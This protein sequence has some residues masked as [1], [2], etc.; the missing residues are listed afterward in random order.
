[1]PMP[2]APDFTATPLDALADYIAGET[3]PP[4]DSW[5]PE[6][7]GRIDIRITA[8]GRWFHEGGEITRPAMVRAFSRLLRREADG[9]HVLVTPAEK[10]AI[11]VED[12]PLIA[13]E[14]RVEGEGAD[15]TILFRLNTDAMV[16]LGPDHPLTLR[17]GP[18]G[19][20]PY[21]RV[22]GSADRPIE[23]RLS[24]STYYSL[25]DYA[26]ENGCIASNGAFYRLGASE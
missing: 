7:E 11:I 25:A 6:R 1:M 13:V 2:I 12:A 17:G 9:S 10:L 26:D 23:A 15:R 19:P 21:L 5:H 3:L 22:S 8:D 20:L 4:V 14:A 16:L 24:R 18:A